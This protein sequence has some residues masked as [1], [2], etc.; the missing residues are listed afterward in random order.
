MPI[1]QKVMH[2][3]I[4]EERGLFTSITGI[5]SNCKRETDRGGHKEKGVKLLD[6]QASQEAVEE[7]SLFSRTNPSLCSREKLAPPLQSLLGTS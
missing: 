4:L 2:R 7:E 5:M 3:L 1:T 6:C